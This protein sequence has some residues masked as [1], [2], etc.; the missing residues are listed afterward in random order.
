MTEPA[1]PTDNVIRVRFKRTKEDLPMAPMKRAA[2]TDRPF[3]TTHFFE[4]D[5]DERTVSC[6]RCGR[7]FDAFEAF[8]HL[9]RQWASYDFNHRNVRGEIAELQK[10]RAKVA[11]QVTNL[12]AQRRRLVPNVRQ[13]VERVRSE[14]WRH[15]HEKNPD[16]A[17]AIMRTIKTRLERVLH[18]L[19]KFGDEEQTKVAVSMSSGGETR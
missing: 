16:I 15:E 3:C 13:D 2:P 5:R 12:K 19:D 11:K 17:G 9:A 4:Y 1:D 7:S 8:E 6:P 18:T 14:L 10:E